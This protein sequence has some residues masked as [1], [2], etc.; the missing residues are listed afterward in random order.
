MCIDMSR[1]WLSGDG[2]PEG[3]QAQLIGVA[4]ETIARDTE[5]FKAGRSVREITDKVW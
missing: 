5:L 2:L 1:T 3:A 4:Q